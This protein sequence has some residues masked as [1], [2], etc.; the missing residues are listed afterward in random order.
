[1]LCWTPSA[2][3]WRRYIRFYA[4]K[5]IVSFSADGLQ[6]QWRAADDKYRQELKDM[7]ARV[8]RRPLLVEQAAHGSSLP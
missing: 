5:H 4:H 6:E 1:M 2:T 8:Q 7:N 3:W